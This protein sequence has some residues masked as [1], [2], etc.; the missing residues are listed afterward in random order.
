VRVAQVWAGKQ[1]GAMHIPRIGQEVIVEF[2]DGDPDRTIIT[3]RVY[4]ND[5]MPPYSLPDHKTQSGTKSRSSKG[6][7]ANNFNEIRFE[8]KEGEEE[9]HIQ[10]EKDMSTLVKNNESISVGGDRSISV[11]GNQST[12]ISGK[13]KSPFHST[14]SMTGKHLLH[15]S[16]TIPIDAPNQIVVK[17]NDATSVT[18]VPGDITSKA[19]TKISPICG[20]T[21]IILEPAKISIKASGG[22]EI[23]LTADV[24]AGSNG[25]S[26]M[27]LDGDA[28]LTGKGKGKAAVGGPSEATLAAGGTVKTNP[29]G[30][31]VA[32]AMVK[33]NS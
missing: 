22:G 10:A 30:V 11:T 14:H 9:L 31:E 8:D 4:N 3:G 6:G 26:P 28:T 24:A 5:N 23:E 20:G 29:A 7:S 25:K 18:L 2:L 17:N 19:P 12:T 27:K 13:G 32:G 33:I 15:A 1:W 21:S 16:D